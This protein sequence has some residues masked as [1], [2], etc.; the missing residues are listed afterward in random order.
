MMALDFI[1]QRE[2]GKPSAELTFW[3]EKRRDG[4]T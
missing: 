3:R 4:E 1:A 2:S